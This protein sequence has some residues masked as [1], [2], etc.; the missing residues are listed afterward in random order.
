MQSRILPQSRDSRSA[1]SSVLALL[2][3][4]AS[5]DQ[6]THTRKIKQ[7]SVRRSGHL[8]FAHS[9][10]EHHCCGR[11]QCNI[12]REHA[13][14]HTHAYSLSLSLCLQPQQLQHTRTWE[15]ELYC[16]LSTTI[17]GAGERERQSKLTRRIIRRIVCCANRFHYPKCKFVQTHLACREA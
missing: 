4:C 11:P 1:C 3:S 16:P 6:D 15:A 10:S 14:T 12:W 2:S 5:D 17:L 8:D 13:H 7:R 9:S